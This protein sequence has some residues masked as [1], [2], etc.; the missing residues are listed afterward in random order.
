MKVGVSSG[1]LPYF[2]HSEKYGRLPE[3][4]PTFIS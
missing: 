4:T 2:S 1:N 3:L